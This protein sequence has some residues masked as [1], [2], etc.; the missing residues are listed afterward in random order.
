MLKCSHRKT[1]ATILVEIEINLQSNCKRKKKKK[2]KQK[3]HL[4]WYVLRRGGRKK[5]HETGCSFGA[6]RT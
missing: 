3:Q 4:K 2:H 6:D 5:K 1:N